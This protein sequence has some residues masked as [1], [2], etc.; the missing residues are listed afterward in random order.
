MDDLATYRSQL[1]Q[2]EAA[3]LGDPGNAELLGLASSLK[4]IIALH[5]QLEPAKAVI[6]GVRNPRVLHYRLMKQRKRR[7]NRKFCLHAYTCRR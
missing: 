5:S 7:T 2:V 4:E 3:L 1:E 6:S